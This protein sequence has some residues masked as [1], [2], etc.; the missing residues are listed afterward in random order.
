MSTVTDNIPISHT[1]DYEKAAYQELPPTPTSL[2]IVTDQKEDRRHYGS[3]S[4]A[5]SSI[6]STINPNDDNESIYLLWTHQLIQE[7]YPSIRDDESIESS[8]THVSTTSW[9]S[10]CF[11]M[12]NT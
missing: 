9:L 11:P 10:A 5:S 6:A 12:C 3:L 7:K 8:I 2:S 4:L 1:K